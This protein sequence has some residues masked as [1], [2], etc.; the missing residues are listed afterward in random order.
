MPFDT[1]WRFL[2]FDAPGAENPGF[3]DSAW[4]G[5][6]VPHDWSIAGPFAEDNPTTGAGAFLPAGIGWYRKRFVLPSADTG[7]RVF[8]DFDGIMAN[9]DVWINGVH[10]GK[11]PNGYV[12][13]RYELTE[14]LHFGT[15]APNILAVRADDSAQPASRWYAGAGIY[16]HVR[17]VVTSPVHV[18]HWGTVV[19]TPSV[20]SSRALVRVQS[21]IINQAPTAARSV[22]LQVTLLGPDGIPVGSG[23]TKVKP[24]APG[25][26]STFSLEIPVPSPRLWDTDHPSL[27]RARV[28]VVSGS[29]IIDGETIPFGIR[30]FRFAAE[31]GFWLNGKNIKLKG[32]C[33]HGDAGALGTAVPLAAW[34]RRL[35]LLKQV[36][37]NAIRTAHNP[38]APEFL[39]L[40]DRMGFLVMDEMFD[41]WTVAKKPYDYHLFF[42]DWARTDVRDT[43]RRDRNHPSIVLYSAGNEI[44]DTGNAVPA[45]Q[46]LASLLAVFH[47]E[48]PT[49]PVTMA[50]FRPNA[51]GDYENGFAD[52]LDVVGQNY[53]EGELLAAHQDKPTRKILGTENGHDRA[54]WIALRDNPAYGGQFLWT[55]FDYLGESRAWPVVGAGSGLFDRTG[56]PRP[57]AFQRQSWWSDTPMVRIVRRAGADRATPAD[58]GFAPLTRRP[59][60]FSDWTPMDTAP[61]TESV[62]AYSNAAQVELFLNDTSLGSL[63]RA[64]DDAP[65][66]WKVPFAPGVLRAVARDASGRVVETDEL[67]TAGKPAKIILI[68]ERDSLPAAWDDV[69]Y[70]TATVTDA[71]G[72]PVPDAADEIAFHVTGPGVIAAVD[73]GDNASHEPFQAAQRRAF[74]GRCVAILRATAP[75][76][77]I[78]LSASAPGL[79]DGAIAIRATAART[80]N[81]EAPE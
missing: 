66:T 39:N 58:P 68:A 44:R 9:S 31:N 67:R 81:G 77:K 16:R 33:L 3:V 24:L 64:A 13:F 34:E 23:A 30:T 56:E 47:Q 59:Q 37:V 27:Y 45:K 72:I 10:L 12:S 74:H 53:R 54:A 26:A 73:S 48:D 1:G 79:A 62:E 43:V 70:V 21:D 4:H 35:R 50:L 25:E 38:P 57:L 42:R 14:H 75:Q 49:R 20:Q 36:G 7:R 51:T 40:C 78:T 41:C 8:V 60:T 61:H 17:L 52:L 15:A 46:T 32:V 6:D 5:V 63:P 71:N 69:L 22:A 2:Q 11:R 28:R 65:R 29:T 80:E 76:G 18:T 55:G 19:T